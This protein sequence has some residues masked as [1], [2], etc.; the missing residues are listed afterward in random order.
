[1]PIGGHTGGVTSVAVSPNGRTVASGGAD[2]TV[3]LESVPAAAGSR[4][5]PTALQHLPKDVLAMKVF[6]RLLAT[7]SVL[8]CAVA[9]A[10]PTASQAAPRPVFGRS[11]VVVPVSGTTYIKESAARASRVIGPTRMQVPAPRHQRTAQLVPSGSIIDVSGSG[12]A[13]ELITAAPHGRAIYTADLSGGVARVTQPRNG[14]GLTNVDMT[15]RRARCGSARAARVIPVTKMRVPGHH[16]YHATLARANGHVGLF[17]LVGKNESAV[18]SGAANWHAQDR[19]DGTMVGD[20]AGQVTATPQE[21]R[22]KSGPEPRRD[23]AQSVLERRAGSDRRAHSALLMLG[24]R[25]LRRCQCTPLGYS[26][27]PP[28]TSAYDQCQTGPTGAPICQTWSFDHAGLRRVSLPASS[29][30]R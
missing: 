25:P 19:C 30:A 8:L 9:M 3:T 21:E 1:M 10:V 15:V 12:A 17:R 7:S 2:S 5:D 4:G 26:S 29:P 22:P 23:V 28:P 11:I 24:Y 27:R 16:K 18:N 13:V 14:G 6:T 20:T